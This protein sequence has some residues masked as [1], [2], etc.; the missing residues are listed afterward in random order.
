MTQQAF[1]MLPFPPSQNSIWRSV[2]GR[3]IKSADYR[4]WITD[5][6]VVLAA[7]NLPKFSGP[8]FVSIAL[9]MPDKRRRDI[10]NRV[11]PLLDLLVLHQVIQRDDS[12]FVPRIY[13][14]VGD[15]F[16]GARVSIFALPTA[17][18]AAARAA[19]VFEGLAQRIHVDGGLFS[20][21][22]PEPRKFDGEAA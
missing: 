2:Q 12:E 7:A 21:I 16:V 3:A 8:V 6:G 10:D 18:K 14:E 4:A 9:G 11:K 1:V 15:G 22:E 13:V 5:A 19:D 20:A 17:D